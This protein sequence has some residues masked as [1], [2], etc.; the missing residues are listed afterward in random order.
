V[1]GRKSA[2]ALIACVTAGGV[3]WSG[4]TAVSRT[5]APCSRGALVSLRTGAVLKRFTALPGEDAVADGR[6]GWYVAGYGLAR[7][8]KDGRVDPDWH[9]ALFRILALGTLKRVRDRLYVSDGRRVFALDAA[10]GRRLWASAAVSGGLIRSVAATRSAVFVGGAFTRVGPVRRSLLAAFGARDGR[11][12]PWHGPSIAYTG[13]SAELA[14]LA[15]TE[16]RLYLGGFFTHI[17]GRPRPSGAAAL[18]VQSGTVTPFAPRFGSWDVTA[19]AARGRLVLVGGTFGGGVFDARTS[20]SR[21]GSGTVSGSKTIALNGSTAYL[22]GD[23]RSS[24]GGHNLLALDLRTGKLRHWFPSI[25]RYVTVSRIA[26][27]GG[28]VFVGGSFCSS[29]G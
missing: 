22:G 13:A 7:L 23:L 29:I 28:R 19:I 25:A 18:R 10:T 1:V 2:L 11:L 24:I 14:A 5:Q 17:G 20:A 8:R 4:G 27:S 3:G 6:G 15:L 9:A 12:L 21:P 16:R 26:V